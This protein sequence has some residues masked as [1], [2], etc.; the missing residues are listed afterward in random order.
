MSKSKGLTPERAREL[1]DYNPEAGILYRKIAYGKA[2]IGPAGHLDPSG[3]LKVSAD[4]RPYFVHRVI[5]LIV[6]GRWPDQIDHAD[7][8]R[9]NNK[10]ANLRE[11][12]TSQNM[13]N[14]GAHKDN[15][16][17][18]KG[19]YF[20]DAG[21]WRAR[22]YHDGRTIS[23]GLFEKLEDAS[24]AYRTAAQKIHGQFARI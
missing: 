18:H 22:I 23:L 14:R 3:Y 9:S 21:K 2:R 19:V 12:T 11:A 8:D 13:A 5:W 1:F 15:K 24:A 10:W 16:Y 17:G 20:H 7:L 6:T 4:C